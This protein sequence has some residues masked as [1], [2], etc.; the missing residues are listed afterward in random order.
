MAKTYKI[1]VS[2][3]VQGVGFRPY[4]YSLAKDFSL[5]GTVSNNE[6]GVIIYVTGAPKNAE[7][8]YDN[9]I[10]NPP[11]VSKIISSA[12][13]EVPIQNFNRFQIIPSSKEGQVNLPLTPD[14]AI[15]DD[16]KKD[17][18]DVKNRRYNYAFTTCVNCGPRWS[19]T[20]TFPFERAHT[21]IADFPM[22]ESCNNEYTNPANRRFHSQTNTCPECG[23]SFEFTDNRGNI[24]K[25]ENIFKTIA[26]Q[27]SEGKIIA[28]KNT[29]GYL[30]CCNAEDD[31]VVKKLRTLKNRPNKPFAVLYPSLELLQNE[32]CL[33]A[34]AID[35]LTSTE[36]PI[37]IISLS[38]YKGHIALQEVAPGLNQL[39]VM[40]PYTGI[41]QL[42]ANQLDVPIVAT[43]GNIHGSP[44]LSHK[45][46]VEVK[47]KSVA[48]YF[49]HH[50]L[51]ITHPQDDSVLK[52]SDKYNFECLF[53]RSRG[54]APNYLNVEVQSNDKILALGADLKNSIAFFPNQH[55]YVGQYLGNLENFDV[56]NRFVEEIKAF[57]NIFEQKP[58][59][60]LVDK[61]PNYQSTQYGLELSK[62][63]NTKLYFIQHHKAHLAAVLGEYGLFK[64]DN[65]LGVV[66]DGTGYGDDGAIWGGEFFKY[67]AGEMERLAHFEYFDW[68]SGDKMSKEPRLSLFSLA[69]ESFHDLLNSKFSREELNVL[70]AIKS[71]NKL[72][73][74]SVGR[75]FDAVSSVLKIC[76]F[77]S[78]EG[79]AAML[80]ENRII[81]YNIGRCVN[82]CK[83]FSGKTIPTLLIL[84]GV[85]S[86]IKNGLETAQIATNFLFTLAS[87]IYKVAENSGSSKICLSGGV[88]QN[89]TLI[90]MLIEL[91]DN[92]YKLYFNRNLTP[93]D[94]NMAFG[95]MMYYLNC[96]NR[97]HLQ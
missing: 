32:A 21:S 23:I 35:V 95:Q 86:D 89:T 13:E 80:L 42:L 28:I 48:D 9:L 90:D 5:T 37:T 69:D 77:N 56:Y 70:T 34:K 57:I 16:C 7:G 54:Y 45:K 93:N 47:L 14:F 17:I 78:F 26:K 4:V 8:F 63:W 12:I 43:S 36:R 91:N 82:Y 52:I 6:H 3:Q 76:D 62:K 61:H 18:A 55:L 87:I 2:G 59:V 49:L 53:R 40:L 19:I 44:I 46:D 75:L 73:T 24:F 92:R 74:S 30:L 85:Q 79:E 11:P 27:L 58:E 33:N 67:N 22:C 38:N 29:S 83:G 96:E 10:K 50:N 41:L 15:C 84:K 39:G 1:I 94:E 68:I 20:K 25:A 72:K 97:T 65:V 81:D 51:E 88:F 66:W 60:I 64:D 71:K 31:G